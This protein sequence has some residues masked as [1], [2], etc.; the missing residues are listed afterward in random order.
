MIISTISPEPLE[1]ELCSPLCHN[2]FLVRCQILVVYS[3]SDADPG[4]G[5]LVPAL[6]ATVAPVR[7]DGHRGG[8]DIGHTSPTQAA[9]FAR[10]LNQKVHS[11]ITLVHEE[12]W[13]IVHLHHALH[14]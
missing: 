1:L 4:R 7:D 5:G 2:F 10:Y 12:R 9:A 3:R 14:E 11:R 6:D 13:Q 8:I